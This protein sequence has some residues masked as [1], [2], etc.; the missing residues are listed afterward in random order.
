M[1]VNLLLCGPFG[2]WA[3]REFL[4]FSWK[5][6]RFASTKFFSSS[7]TYLNL[8]F[9]MI[10]INYRMAGCKKPDILWISHFNLN[11]SAHLTSFLI[12]RIIM[13]HSPNQCMHTWVYIMSNNN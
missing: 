4:I 3:H 10:I 7:K 5:K 12:I 6:I 11:A 1:E 13:E 2:E 8:L 9:L